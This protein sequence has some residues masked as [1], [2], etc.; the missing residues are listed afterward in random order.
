MIYM[1]ER[2][3]FFFFRI[4]FSLSLF[5]LVSK[6]L[7]EMVVVAMNIARLCCCNIS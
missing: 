6:M 1:S 5:Y 7:C 4:D 2:S 3:V